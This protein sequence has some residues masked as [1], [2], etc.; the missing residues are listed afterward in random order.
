MAISF[1]IHWNP[2][3]SEISHYLWTL[4]FAFGNFDEKPTDDSNVLL[5][6][7][8]DTNEVKTAVRF[9]NP[10]ANYYRIPTSVFIA[11]RFDRDFVSLHRVC[12]IRT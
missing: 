12:T 2:K 4:L 7:L 3:F 11:N 10:P 9:Y 5:L 1:D 8:I 6:I